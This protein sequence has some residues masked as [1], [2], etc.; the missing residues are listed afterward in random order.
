M[1][2]YR[3]RLSGRLKWLRAVS[4]ETDH[5]ST[6]CHENFFSRCEKVLKRSFSSS[7]VLTHV[8]TENENLFKKMLKRKVKIKQNSV[9]QVLHIKNRG[10]SVGSRTDR[11]PG[12]PRPVS[13]QLR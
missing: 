3:S 9:E 5:S 13:L 8:I 2:A 12:L 4:D 11:R 1:C 6:A 7:T 10:R